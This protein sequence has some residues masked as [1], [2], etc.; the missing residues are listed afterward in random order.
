MQAI[1][2]LGER[3]TDGHIVEAVTIPWF[4]IISEIERDAS[5]LHEVPWPRLEELVAGGYEFAGYDVT[6]TPRSGDGGRDIIAVK[7]GIC[8][9]RIIDQIKAY[10]PGRRVAANDVRALLGVLSSDLN[11]SKGIV[12]T[13]AEFAPRIRDDPSIKPF[14]PFRLE[15]RNGIQ[16]RKWLLG[17]K[18]KSEQ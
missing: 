3:T 4:T 11:A 12:T 2:S 18:A 13:N 6:L 9:I 10:A 1:V 5:F 14:M 16:L 7:H 15:L 17:L 8:S